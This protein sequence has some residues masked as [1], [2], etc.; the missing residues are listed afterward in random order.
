MYNE[1]MGGIDLADMVISFNRLEVKTRGCYI[2]VF[3]HMVDI[4]NVNK[5]MASIPKALQI[6]RLASQ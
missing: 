1:N 5:C 2:K 3:W 4:A 6:S